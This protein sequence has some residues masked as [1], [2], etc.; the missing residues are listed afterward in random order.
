M[1]WY[2]DIYCCSNKSEVDA[3]NKQKEK[4]KKLNKTI[5]NKKKTIRKRTANK[6]EYA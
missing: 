3:L 1:G 6:D 4:A 2:K 5:E